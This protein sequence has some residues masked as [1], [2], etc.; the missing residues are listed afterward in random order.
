M[1]RKGMARPGHLPGDLVFALSETDMISAILLAA[2]ESMRM[3]QPKQMLEWRG[4]SL[5]RHALDHLVQSDVDDIV[6]VLGHKAEEIRKSLTEYQIKMVINPDYRVGMSSSL[7]CG[8]GSIDPRSEA[9]LVLLA[10]QPE[11]GP[12]MINRLIHVF[13]DADPKPG[14]VRPVYR[15][16]RGHPV[17]IGIQYLGEALQLKGD[18]GARGILKSHPGNILEIEVD[19]DV[20][21]KD[22]DTPEDYRSYLP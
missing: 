10:D 21:L 16:V 7:R 5:L 19:Q 20:I 1:G 3:G 6:L 11:I 8:L 12:E 15:G 18:E 22:I 4:K 9:F 13:R 14:I 17:L 2:G